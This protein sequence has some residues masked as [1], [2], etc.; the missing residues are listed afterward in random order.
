VRGDDRRPCDGG[1]SVGPVP[2][3][4]QVE[5]RV[6]QKTPAHRGFSRENGLT[7]GDA[8]SFLREDEPYLA[9]LV[10]VYGDLATMRE[11]SEQ[12]LVGER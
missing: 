6:Q 3:D 7:S 5:P 9:R 12:Q 4:R 11:A 10:D 1:I 8:G 2:T